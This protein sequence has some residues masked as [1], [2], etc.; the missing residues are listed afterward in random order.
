MGSYEDFQTVQFEELANLMTLN[1]NALVELTY[2]MVPLLK[3]H[4]ESF[5][6]NVASI[7]A[8]QPIPRF[9]TYAATK[10]F[11]S[12]FSLALREELLADGIFVT[13]LY[14]GVTLTEFAKRMGKDFSPFLKKI[15]HTASEVV[16]SSLKALFKKR[17]ICVPGF[18]NKLNRL[19][20]KI[21]PTSWKLA[22]AGGSMK[23][24]F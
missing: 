12:F 5:I 3:T 7:A 17:R 6:L 16:H 19:I 2:K 15:S 22:L 23:K 1:M 20:M 21:L 14:P 13:T 11:V 4:D 10:S 8:F 24:F 18:F 9:S